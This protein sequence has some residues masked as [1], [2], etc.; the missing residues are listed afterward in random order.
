MTWKRLFPTIGAI[1]L[2]PAVTGGVLADDE[3]AAMLQAK[4]T[5]TEA[6]GTA[7]KEAGGRAINAGIDDNGGT[8]LIRVVVA[9]SDSVRKVLIDAQTG[10]VVKM[11][12]KNDEEEEDEDHEDDEDGEEGDE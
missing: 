3:V 6:I 4:V 5:L 10:S 9:R 2:V 8:L 11:T 7:E 1:A 12:A